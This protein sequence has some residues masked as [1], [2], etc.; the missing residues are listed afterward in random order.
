M[1]EYQALLKELMKLS[2]EFSQSNQLNR[3]TV[4]IN[5]VDSTITLPKETKLLTVPQK[6]IIKVLFSLKKEDE[7]DIKDCLCFK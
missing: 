4:Y 2:F 1:L 5:A 3:N 7:D 6:E